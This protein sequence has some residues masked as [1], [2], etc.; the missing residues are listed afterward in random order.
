MKLWELK[1]EEGVH[2]YRSLALRLERG[3]WK[4]IAPTATKKFFFVAVG[5]IFF[6]R[7][8]VWTGDWPGYESQGASCGQKRLRKNGSPLE[9][10]GTWFSFRLAIGMI[11]VTLEIMTSRSSELYRK[12]LGRVPVLPQN[13]AIAIDIFF[14]FLKTLVQFG[15]SSGRAIPRRWF[16]TVECRFCPRTRR[17][18]STSRRRAALAQWP[19]C[20]QVN[21]SSW[22]VCLFWIV[23]KKRHWRSLGGL[24]G[25]VQALRGKDRDSLSDIVLQYWKLELAKTPGWRPALCLCGCM[26]CAYARREVRMWLVWEWL[27]Q[28]KMT[29]TGTTVFFVFGSKSFCCTAGYYPPRSPVWILRE[30]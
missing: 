27:S 13:P 7:P 10:G 22:K 12:L 24:F 17:S 6:H 23:K 14:F 11:P 5:A 18:R 28:K 8:L 20:S 19:Q 1:A 16:S 29:A 4:K 15:R 3:R 21:W 26:H 25:K 9:F 30:G 2:W